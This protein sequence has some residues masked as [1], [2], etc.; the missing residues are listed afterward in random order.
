MEREVL[1][2][3]PEHLLERGLTNF[4]PYGL[5]SESLEIVFFA[6]AQ[7]EIVQYFRSLQ[8][9]AAYDGLNPERDHRFTGMLGWYKWSN[10]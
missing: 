2:G 5:V 4:F 6:Q 1:F 8:T 3:S 10:L 7:G 9:H